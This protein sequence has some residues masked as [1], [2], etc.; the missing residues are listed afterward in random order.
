G[1]LWRAEDG[2]P[3]G[4][5][6][7][8]QDVVSDVAFS[9]DGQTIASCG[10]D[11]TAH[12]WDRDGTPRHITL[13]HPGSVVALAFSPDGNTLLTGSYDTTA[14]LWRVADGSPIGPPLVH[15]GPVVAVAFSPDGRSILTGSHDGTARLWPAPTALAGDARRLSL[16][17][18]VLTGIE[19]TEDRNRVRVLDSA[20]WLERRRQLEGLG[21]PP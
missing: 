1:R 21:G 12:F 20:T 10:Y 14:R 15:R 8:H 2:T 5:V 19:L 6:M 7:A 16:W 3:I 18:T 11:N 4:E 13:L 9:P 17:V